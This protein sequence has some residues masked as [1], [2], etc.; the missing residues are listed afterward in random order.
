M[1]G[2]RHKCDA[3]HMTTS[4]TP[5]SA[6]EH[7]PLTGLR[8]GRLRLILIATLILTV[9][10]CG[11]YTWTLNE[12]VMYGPPGLF[13]D[14]RVEDP[15]LQT[16][17][18]QAIIDAEIREARQLDTLVCSDA[19][20]ASLAGI[21]VFAG[22]RRISFDNNR[23]SDAETLALLPRLE[24]L[25]L[26]GNQLAGLEPLVCAQSLG[27]IALAGNEGLDC[28]DLEYLEDC[29]ITVIDRPAHCG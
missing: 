18:D 11:D 21:E 4:A 1:L 14:F 20:I 10:G 24:L 25:H 15:A 23:I 29:G 6:C 19:G 26:R 8:A 9:Y 2:N 17:L 22:L 27:E 3:Q 16:C 7:E 13:R 5:P 12:Q 28:V